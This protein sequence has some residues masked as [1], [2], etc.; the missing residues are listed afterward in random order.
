[1]VNTQPIFP[2]VPKTATGTIANSDAQ[3]VK[4]VYTAG[5]SGGRVA[6]LV[7]VSTD[8]VNHDVGIYLGGNLV[9]TVLVPAG[10]GTSSSAPPIDVFQD[11]NFRSAYYDTAG[12]PVID[13]AASTVLGISSV[14]TVTSAKTITGT[15]SAADF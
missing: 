2:S 1:M 5:I 3:T 11:P 6:K 9:G 7:L 12:N 14:V 15:A 4:A 13:M 8:T 10:A